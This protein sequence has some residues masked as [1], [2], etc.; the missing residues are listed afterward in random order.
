M[1]LKQ[2]G[3][4]GTEDDRD[5]RDRQHMHSSTTRALQ[6]TAAGGRGMRG[7]PGDQAVLGSGMAGIEYGGK[8]MY[9]F[10]VRSPFV[11]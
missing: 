11:L 2:G 10:G 3:S 9:G 7:A 6:G 8:V 4:R 1:C 5:R